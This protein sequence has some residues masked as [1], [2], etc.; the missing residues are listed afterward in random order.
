[1]DQAQLFF[2]PTSILS[3]TNG[4]RQDRSEDFVSVWVWVFSNIK[5]KKQI[6]WSSIFGRALHYT[7]FFEK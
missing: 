3:S 5:I 7:Y 6:F 4:Y 2:L 1:M